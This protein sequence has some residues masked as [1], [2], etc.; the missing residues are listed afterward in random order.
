MK[1]I[2]KIYYQKKLNGK[3]LEYGDLKDANLSK[4]ELSEFDFSNVNFG[5]ANFDGSILR[6]CDLRGADLSNVKGLNNAQLSSNEIFIYT[7]INKDTKFPKDFNLQNDVVIDG[8]STDIKLG[9]NQW[10]KFVDNHNFIIEKYVLRYRLCTKIKDENG[11][12][13]K[14]DRNNQYQH[15][16]PLNGKCEIYK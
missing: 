11:N 3:I 10:I 4:Q 6:G 12:E 1:Q 5:E 2:K 7:K 15:S 14:I 13:I 16:H 9:E 8:D